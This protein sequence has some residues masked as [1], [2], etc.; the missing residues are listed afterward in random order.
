MGN[1][2]EKQQ[3]AIRAKLREV[4]NPAALLG[5]TPLPADPLRQSVS[6]ALRM[7][8]ALPDHELGNS[9]KRR[10]PTATGGVHLRR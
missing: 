5:E 8:V 1:S 9:W 3:Y 10:N 4:A 6:S 7:T 2:A